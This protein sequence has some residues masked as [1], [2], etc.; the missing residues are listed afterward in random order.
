MVRFYT[1]QIS[2]KFWFGI[3]DSI[4][5]NAFG[6]HYEDNYYFHSCFCAVAKANIGPTVYCQACFSS[7]EDHCKAIDSNQTWHVSDADVSY[8]FDTSDIPN[9]RVRLAELEEVVGC[10]MEHFRI[11]DKKGTVEYRFS[12][13][14]GIRADHMALVAR[15]CL[16]KQ[17]LYCLETYGT[18]VFQ[19]DL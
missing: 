7:Y 12:L 1:G 9:L 15:L 5:A 13:P 16:G 19:A 17:I 18:C 8:A 10:H 14:G 4:D 3:Q 11:V 6:R 2:G